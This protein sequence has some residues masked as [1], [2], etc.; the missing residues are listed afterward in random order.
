MAITLGQ[1]ISTLR[2][3]KGITQE[4]LSERLGV[5]PQAVS[6]WENDISSPDISL[7]VELAEIL[8][9]SVDQILSREEK[10]TVHLVPEEERK[11]VEDMMLRIIINSAD[12]DKI[13]VNLP[14]SLVTAGLELGMEMPQVSGNENLKDIDL[15]KVIEMVDKGV[16]GK[17]VEMESAEG[18]IIEIEVE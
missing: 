14:M 12:G 5:S 18:D 2:K 8:G 15:S 4:G 9:V 11:K 17:L 1:K 6:K 13:R 7:L 16:V 10:K 3:E